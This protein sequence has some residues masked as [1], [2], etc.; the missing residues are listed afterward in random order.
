MIFLRLT[1]ISKKNKRNSDEF[2]Y[3]YD[4]VVAPQ[5][6]TKANK[7]AI[8]AILPAVAEAN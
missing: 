7:A 6:A 5:V 8:P 2:L 1:I 3:F 4:T